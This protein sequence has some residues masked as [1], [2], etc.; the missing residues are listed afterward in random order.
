VQGVKSRVGAGDEDEF[1]GAREEEVGGGEADAC[2][3][4]VRED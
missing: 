4:K 3:E 1:V 2:V